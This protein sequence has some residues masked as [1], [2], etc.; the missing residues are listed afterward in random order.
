MVKALPVLFYAFFFSDDRQR[1]AQAAFA[2]GL[3]FAILENMIMLT[4]NIGMGISQNYKNAY[5]YLIKDG[6]L[7]EE[8]QI[9]REIWTSA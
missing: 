3:G 4:Q 2:V 1:L 6:G 7:C 5:N 8:S 9:A